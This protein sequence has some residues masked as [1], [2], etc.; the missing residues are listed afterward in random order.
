MRIG[1]EVADDLTTERLEYA[2]VATAKDGVRAEPKHIAQTLGQEEVLGP[3]WSAVM[4]FRR[5]FRTLSRVIA[6]TT[7]FGKRHFTETNR[8]RTAV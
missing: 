1:S 6:P 3:T 4:P 8:F 2:L 7:R 5:A